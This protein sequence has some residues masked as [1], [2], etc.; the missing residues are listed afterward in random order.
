MLEKFMSW[1]SFFLK[2]HNSYCF[3]CVSRWVSSIELF[4]A[5]KSCFYLMSLKGYYACT[6]LMIFSEG[7]VI[8]F[9]NRS[10]NFI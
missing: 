6:Y 8:F 5:C 10:V 3:K 2:D 9:L 4:A 7:L 1:F